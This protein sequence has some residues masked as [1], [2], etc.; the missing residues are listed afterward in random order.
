MTSLRAHLGLSLVLWAGRALGQAPPHAPVAAP[1]PRDLAHTAG[2]LDGDGRAEEVHLYSDGS[3]RVFRGGAEVVDRYDAH[4]GAV[5]PFEDGS[6]T[7][8]TPR[9]SVVDIDRRDRQRELMLEGAHGDEDPDHEFSFWVLREGRLWPML[10]RAH[11]ASSAVVAQHG[12]RPAIPGDGTVRVRYETCVREPDAARRLSGLVETVVS[13]YVLADGAV[14]HGELLENITTTRRPARCAMVACPIV[15]VGADEARVGAILRDLRGAAMER[16]QSLALPASRVDAD[17]VLTVTIREEEREVTSL[18]GVYLEADGRRIE[19]E[20]CER[21][22][23]PW[24][25]DDGERLTMPP[26]AALRLR[27]R[28]GSA[29]RLVL[30]AE[31]SYERLPPAAP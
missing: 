29:R 1:A 19:P 7:D 22:R 20:G 16:W 28:V 23:A 24:C 18:D 27:F 21:G 9:L 14:P 2:D 4:A 3:L 25:A 26:G 13:R 11:D 8:G 6:F 12:T 17:G 15:H 10:H 30:W 31:G 5:A